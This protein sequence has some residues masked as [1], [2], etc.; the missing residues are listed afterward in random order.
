MQ[1][2]VTAPRIVSILSG[3]I[4]FTVILLITAHKTELEKCSEWFAKTLRQF[5]F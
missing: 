5:R 2:H 1:T 3:K 4:D